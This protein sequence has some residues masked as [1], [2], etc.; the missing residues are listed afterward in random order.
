M[1][2]DR[3]PWLIVL[4]PLMLGLAL[5][6]GFLA[7]ARFGT[8]RVVNTGL[9]S[10]HRDRPI[11]KLDQVIELI[12]RNYVDSV[13]EGELVDQ[14]LQDM[15]QKLDPHSY[16]ISAA[17]LNAVQEPLKGSFMGIGVEFSIQ[18]DTIV[19]ITP[20]EGGPSDKLGIRAGDRILSADGKSLAGVHVTNDEVMKALRGD[21]GTKFTVAILRHN[22]KTFDVVI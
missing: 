16:Y 6:A 21:K 18:H 11:D 1:N 3:K 7:G 12:D 15:L 4:L 13:R 8:P 17:E 9:F 5:A 20:V 14:V 10:F 19:V 2:D 22:A